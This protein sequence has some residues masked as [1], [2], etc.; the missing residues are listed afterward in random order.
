M[1]QKQSAG[2]LLFK[3]NNGITKFFL[4]HPGGPFWKNKN[5]GAWTIPKG[6]FADNE[7][8]L[9]AAKREFKEETGAG[10]TGDFITLSPIKQKGGKTVFGWAIEGD[11]DAN[12][13]VSNTFE[14]EWPPK[15]GKKQIFPEIDRSEWFSGEEAKQKINSSQ[16]ILLDEL[17]DILKKRN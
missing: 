2:I 8:A 11:L 16:A 14:M 7:N 10:L 15:S 12:N 5:Y 6:E 13:I 9:E 4:V 1:P 17:I 3:I